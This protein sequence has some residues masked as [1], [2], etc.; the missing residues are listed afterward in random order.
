MGFWSHFLI[1]YNDLKLYS[2]HH[3]KAR[4]NRIGIRIKGTLISILWSDFS[5][6]FITKMSLL[7]LKLKIDPEKGLWRSERLI[8]I[9]TCW[10]SF[11][12]GSSQFRGG[13]VIAFNSGAG[14]ASGTGLRDGFALVTELGEIS[15]N[16]LNKQL[17]RESWSLSSSYF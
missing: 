15:S 12:L 1:S 8:F 5:L 4:T 16:H 6:I 17:V 3:S 11:H 14:V 9:F 2:S 7:F 13:N 10:G